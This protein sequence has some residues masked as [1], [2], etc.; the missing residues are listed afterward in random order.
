MSIKIKLFLFTGLALL[1][2]L[3]PSFLGLAAL[4]QAEDKLQFV[5][6][7]VLPRVM[8]CANIL[9]TFKD[10]RIDNIYLIYENE[11]GFQTKTKKR[12]LETINRLNGYLDDYKNGAFNNTDLKRHQDFNSLLSTYN[13]LYSVVMAAKATPPELPKAIE[14]WRATGVKL[15]RL[16]TDMVDGIKQEADQGKA[17][18]SAEIER[19]QKT[20]M[21]SL[22]VSVLMLLGCGWV[23]LRSINRPVQ[24]AMSAV[25]L[26]SDRQ[27]LSQAV[28]VNGRDEIGGLLQAF[29][30]LLAKMRASIQN[31]GSQSQAVT[32]AA[33]DL[34]VASDQVKAGAQQASLSAAEMAAAIEEVTVSINHIAAR[35][36]DADQLAVESGIQVAQGETMIRDTVLQIENIATAVH[37]AARY[38]NQLQTRTESIGSVVEVIGD[39]A[40]QINLLALNAAIEAARAGEYG[41]GFAVVADEVRKLAERTTASTTQITATVASIREGSSETVQLMDNVVLRV[42]DGVTKVRTTG[43]TIAALRVLAK[44]VE[45]QVSDIASAIQEQSHASGLIAQKVENIAQIAEHSRVAADSTAHNAQR[46][47]TLAQDMRRDVACYTT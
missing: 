31:I 12:R 22:L 17:A 13:E 21:I 40:G 11:E 14:P 1:A 34:S 18:A 25:Q 23:I 35:T 4:R 3:I 26:I 16:V 44:R 32:V 5:N 9:G 38:I 19:A 20:F 6:E 29:N 7:R 39:I 46:L 2:S 10:L 33:E 43:E 28:V 36:R 37:E 47:H 15:G 27:D 45:Q 42:G 30:Q 24:A 8:L 41:R